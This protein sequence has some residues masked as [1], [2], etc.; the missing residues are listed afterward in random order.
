MKI[1]IF[2]TSAP[3]SPRNIHNPC[4]FLC[5]YELRE[6][7]IR[8]F[9]GNSQKSM[10]SALFH[11]FMNF[12]DFSENDENSWNSTNLEPQDMQNRA[13][14][15]TVSAVPALGGVQNRHFHEIPHIFMKFHH[16]S[17]FA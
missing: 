6:V 8:V 4:H 16:F 1:L 17:L 11:V 15:H 12:K 10:I 3:T 14:I 2:S 5:F 7:G 13:V 9:H